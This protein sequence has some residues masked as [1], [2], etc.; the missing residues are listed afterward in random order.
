MAR[1]EFA[2]AL[3]GF[4]ALSVVVAHYTGFFFGN[5][6]LIGTMANTPPP[7]QVASSALDAW[8]TVAHAIPVAG[9]E[10]GVALFFLISG[11]VIPM[12]LEK[13][14]WRG[15]LVGRVMRIYPTYFA[16][17][18]V[19][20]VALWVA[21]SLFGRPFPFDAGA[22]I[23]HYVPGVR[24]LMWSPHIDYVVWT[25]EIE[26]RFYIVCTLAWI[27]LQRG[28]RGVFAIPLA[29]GGCAIGIQMLLPGWFGS[30]AL[31]YRLGFVFATIARFLAFMFIGV[32]FCYHYRGRLGTGSLVTVSAALLALFWV[33]WSRATD[34]LSWEIIRS[35]T[36]A[37]A[38]F[39]VSYAFSNRWPPSRLLDFFADISFPLY[40]VH[41]VAGYVA[42]RIMLAYDVPSVVAF[43]SA[44][45]G[46]LL[47]SW[48]VHI[49]VEVP[50][51]RLGRRWARAMT[52]R[53]R[54]SDT[55]VQSKAA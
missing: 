16:G 29:L 49:A 22:V 39:A 23:I 48:I 20:L 53:E 14:D 45:A 21:G 38:V 2:N 41:G 32:A 33:L 18:T 13:Y 54:D 26:V 3:R 42:L 15:F 34:T 12:S 46:A 44:L 31:A 9:G 24:D 27:W 6:S 1:L 43:L 50:T 19:T 5:A 30:N 51:H 36:F 55:P 10:F 17:F 52:R 35:Y 7:P 28:E 40:V 8:Q 25:L 47:A 11:F 4:A 37:L